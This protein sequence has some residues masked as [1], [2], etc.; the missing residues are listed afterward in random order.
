MPP[1]EAVLEEN[2][3]LKGQV[4]S[5]SGRVAELESQLA[6]FKKQFFGTGKNERQDKAQ[7]SLMLGL[8]ETQLAE[9]KRE[10]VTYERSQSPARDRHRR[11]FLRIF[12]SRRRSN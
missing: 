11:R 5:L 2:Q 9:A 12:P 4:E 7:L 1:I 8:L 10:T 3:V 6:L